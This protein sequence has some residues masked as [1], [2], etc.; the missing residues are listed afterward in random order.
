MGAPR[1]PTSRTADPADPG[2]ALALVS[3]RRGERWP[4][5]GPA[6]RAASIGDTRGVDRVVMHMGR[7]GLDGMVAAFKRRA[8]AQS[9]GACRRAMSRCVACKREGRMRGCVQGDDPQVQVLG[10]VGGP[11]ALKSRVRFRHLYLY[12]SWHLCAAGCG[13]MPPGC[14]AG[15]T[16]M[17]QGRQGPDFRE[18]VVMLCACLSMLPVAETR[19][20]F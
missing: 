9:E 6:G 5:D 10:R 4:E 19:A 2:R 8:C 17:R 12:V 3:A 20:V 18:D 13:V 11:R 15:R 1:S 14:G 7:C 16:V